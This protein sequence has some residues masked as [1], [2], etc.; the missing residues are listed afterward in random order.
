VLGLII[1]GTKG[2]EETHA[3]GDFDCPQCG[4][5]RPYVH[6]RIRRYFT[7]Y[8]IP[9]IP[10]NVA[11][12]YVECGG[13]AGTFKKGVLELTSQR[14]QFQA[15]FHQAVR[16]VALKMMVADGNIDDGEVDVV[17][18]V[19]EKLT[20]R[21]PDAGEIRAQGE[22]LA[23]DP[24]PVTALVASVKDSLND[25]GKDLVLAAAVLV[26]SADGT[27]ADQ[28]RLLLLGIGEALG[29]DQGRLLEQLKAV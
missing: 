29:M 12:E 23:K 2:V 6:K 4:T 15:E 22:L 27:I 28:E 21:R 16:D 11:G 10:I 5:T 13:C 8:F 3:R 25:K 26:A 19:V 24:R 17:C 7:L 18:G 14:Q 1:Y 9:L 20:G